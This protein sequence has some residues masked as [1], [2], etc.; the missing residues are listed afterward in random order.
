MVLRIEPQPVRRLRVM[1][2]LREEGPAWAR[3]SVPELRLF[4][5]CR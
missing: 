5:A 3:W 2:G 4:S 1:V